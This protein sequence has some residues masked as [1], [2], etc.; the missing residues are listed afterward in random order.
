M[1]LESAHIKN[2]KLLEDVDLIFSTDPQ[3]PL[4]V[5]R[6]ESGS[7]KT[8]ILY[9]LRWAMYGNGDVPKAMRLTAATMPPGEPVTVQ[10]RVEFT[11]DAG[12]RYRLIR[13]CTETPGDSDNFEREPDRLRLLHRTPSGE[14]NIEEG[15]EEL[16]RTF[17]PRNLADV[18]F[19]NGD[20]VQRFI[21]SGQQAAPRE[22]Q[23]A[24]HF[25][26]RQLLGL[27]NIEVAEN[28]LSYIVNKLKRELA[29]G[30][31]KELQDAT[32]KLEEIKEQVEQD[33]NEL[34]KIHA[35]I[36]EVKDQIR[37]DERELNNIR[38][39]G[40]L[41]VIQARIRGLKSDVS[42]I[43]EQEKDVQ[44]RMKEL[45]QSE[46]LSW[47]LLGPRLQ[48]GLNILDSLADR[49]VIPGTSIEVLSD[50]L[51]LGICICGE[52]LDE[53]S[54]RHDHIKDLIEQQH[55]VATEPQR[56]TSLFHHAR[57]SSQTHQTRIIAKQS[58]DDVAVDL[59][60][61]YTDC[62]DAQRLKERDLESEREKRAQIDEERVR[63]LTERIDNNKGKQSKFER[64]YGE[65][66]GRL[67]GHKEEEQIAKER[68]QKAK[69]EA[70]LNETMRL[71]AEVAEDLRDLA[72]ETLSSLKSEYV[73]RVSDRM[74]E[75]FLDIAGSGPDAEAA[76]FTRVS[77]NERFDIVISTQGG[78]TL[79]A[80]YELN[81]ASQR[82]LT[83]SFIWALM[84]VAQRQAPRIIDTPLGMTSGAVKH[85]MV[86]LLTRPIIENGLPYQVVLF[87]TRSEIRDIE[88]LIDERAGTILTLSCSK[89]Y[90]RDLVN[91]WANGALTVKACACNH[92]EVCSICERRNDIGRFTVRDGGI[93]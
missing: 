87:M 68:E 2:F 13:T 9:A 71:R 63:M 58:F 16:I 21:S 35:R 77:I 5:I 17:L 70:D 82:A 60:Q 28:D 56:L 73:Q 41:E 86:E 72:H 55:R 89:D 1:R 59:L 75:L 62:R 90:P 11:T 45:L 15:K 8:S 47:H 38:G 27:D 53:G 49:K 80:D 61:K 84:E 31:G 91:E 65:V 54:D 20:D 48:K 50:R 33:D 83:L 3:Q 67:D 18:F 92:R 40:D 29:A 12:E 7:G 74:N 36:S 78:N 64:E 25:A 39:I 46:S 19:T 32:A 22:R 69:D 79:D 85:R 76:A 81:G 10:V 4:T 93:A 23:K 6:A 24:V 26:I 52:K 37:S 57:S 43:E 44:G 88:E 14:K 42:R 51:E 34:N 30:G 66:K